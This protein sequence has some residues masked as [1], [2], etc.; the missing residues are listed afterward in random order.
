[1]APAGLFFALPVAP[2]PPTKRVVSFF[3]GQNLFWHAKAAFGYQH[4]NHDPNLLSVAV[5]RENGWRCHGVRF[6][7][8]TPSAARSHGG[9]GTGSA[10]S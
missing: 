1:M 8:G 10:A 6:Y 4:P 9:T 2:E 7:T 5:C 3:D